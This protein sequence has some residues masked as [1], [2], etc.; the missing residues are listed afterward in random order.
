M[1]PFSA[2]AKHACTVEATTYA[3]KG[4]ETTSAS[5]VQLLRMLILPEL[6]D[7]S[8]IVDDSVPLQSLYI[9]GV[10]CRDLFTIGC[11]GQSSHQRR[12]LAEELDT[13]AVMVLH[14]LRIKVMTGKLSSTACA[15]LASVSR[16]GPLT[17]ALTCHSKG[18]QEQEAAGK[19]M[20]EHLSNLRVDFAKPF[21][22]RAT[23]F[24]HA[25]C[26]LNLADN[27]LPLFIHLTCLWLLAGREEGQARK[28]VQVCD[29]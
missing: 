11:P 27:P 10:I 20:H 1:R 29:W 28:P 13:G 5:L 26:F 17:V 7:H 2:S 18:G 6:A 9:N 15:T 8:L 16:R 23:L 12:A 19:Q 14:C 22:A 3:K 24:E 4:L 25:R 21:P